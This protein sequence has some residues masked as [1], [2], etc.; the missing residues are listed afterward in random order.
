[1]ALLHTVPQPP[2]LFGSV[3][4]FVSQ[5]SFGVPLQSP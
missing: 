1:L 3:V 4:V 2:Q 5:P